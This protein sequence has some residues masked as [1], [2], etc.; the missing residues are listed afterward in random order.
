MG[1]WIFLLLFYFPLSL[2]NGIFTFFLPNK[3][4]IKWLSQPAIPC[5]RGFWSVWCGANW[6]EDFLV[7]I[8]M[9]W[10]H[11]WFP[12]CWRGLYLPIFIHFPKLLFSS[13]TFYIFNLFTMVKLIFHFLLEIYINCSYSIICIWN[14][15]IIHLQHVS[16]IFIS[17]IYNIVNN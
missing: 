6:A 3:N 1:G 2:I 11:R 13:L 17:Q 9:T 4:K 14:E 7:H 5:E 10:T 15:L 12:I 8:T 16:S